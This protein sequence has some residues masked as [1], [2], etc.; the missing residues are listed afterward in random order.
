MAGAK[1]GRPPIGPLITARFTERLADALDAH[2]A[3]TGTTRSDLLRR[4]AT[5]LLHQETTM[6]ESIIDRLTE[7]GGWLSA[8]EL[9]DLAPGAVVPIYAYRHELDAADDGETLSFGQDA[10][11][12]AATAPVRTRVE[13]APELLATLDRLVAAGRVQRSPDGL[14]RLAN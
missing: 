4:G 1:G 9:A 7:S 11:G 3:A 5:L 13:P 2:A 14:Y 12:L 8:R 10:T 6:I